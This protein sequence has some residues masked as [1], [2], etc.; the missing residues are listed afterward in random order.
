MLTVIIIIEVGEVRKVQSRRFLA[1]NFENQAEVERKLRHFPNSR[2]GQLVQREISIE[3]G[4]NC[5]W[6]ENL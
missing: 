3:H 2:K 4:G 1:S 6:N 5:T